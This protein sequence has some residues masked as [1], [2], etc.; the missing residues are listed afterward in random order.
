MSFEMRPR[1]EPGARLL[2]AIRDVAPLLSERVEEAGRYNQLCEQNYRDM[3]AV[4]IAGAFVPD[5]LGGMGLQ[6]MHDG[7]LAVCALARADGSTAIA[8]NM[9]FSATRGMAAHDTA[10]P[11]PAGSSPIA[12]HV[13]L[14]VRARNPDGNYIVNDQPRCSR[15]PRSYRLE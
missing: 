13:S 8:M 5:D 10:Q 15:V 2:A 12:T 4:S 6:S 11:E 9:H 3:Q 14:K 1:T 7:I